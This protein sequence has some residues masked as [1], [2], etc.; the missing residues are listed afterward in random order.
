MTSVINEIVVLIAIIAI[1][2]NSFGYLN[3]VL[4]YVLN[5]FNDTLFA[6]IVFIVLIIGAIF[7]ILHEKEEKKSG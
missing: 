2:L 3:I 6:S 7:Y 5:Q 1:F 4:D